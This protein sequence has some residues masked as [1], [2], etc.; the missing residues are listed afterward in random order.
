MTTTE[1]GTPLTYV[2]ATDGG[3]WCVGDLPPLYQEYRQ[4]PRIH[5][6]FDAKG[7]AGVEIMVGD[8]DDDLYRVTW[9]YLASGSLFSDASP[10]SERAQRL[11]V[12]GEDE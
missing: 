4:E 9:D 10:S 12:G 1:A 7:I 8:Y 5:Q 3:F 11:L 6:V 2:R